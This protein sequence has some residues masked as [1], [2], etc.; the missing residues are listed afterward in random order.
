MSIVQSAYIRHVLEGV[1]ARVA[2]AAEVLDWADGQATLNAD[3]LIPPIRSGDESAKKA[4]ER[5]KK[6]VQNFGPRAI[7]YKRAAAIGTVNWGG[8]NPNNIDARLDNIDLES[9]AKRALKNLVALGIAG[10]IPHAPEGHKPRLQILGGYL[11]P[12]YDKGDNEEPAAW[13][14]VTAETSGN[15]F[16]LRIYEP[17]PLTPL[18]GT[19]TEWREQRH[20]W[21]FGNAPSSVLEGVL[22]PTVVMSDTD[23]AGLPIGELAQALPVLKA[24]IA[25]QI[26]ILRAAEANV[27]PTRWA[28]GDW[29]FGNTKGAEDVLIAQSADSSIGVIDPPGLGTLFEQH[30]RILERVRGD[31]KLPVSS[32]T[33]GTFPS[34]EALDQANAIANATAREYATAIARLLTGGV[35]GFALALGMSDDDA[36]PVSVE[37]NREQERR[38]VSEQI[39]LDWRDGLISFRAAVTAVSQFY[40]TWE[41]KDVEAF[42]KANEELLP[43]PETVNSTAL[44]TFEPVEVE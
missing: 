8:D 14:Q 33:T 3:E 31:L 26:R 36:P 38:S 21:E 10:V 35:R 25:Q 37:V 5:F 18:V 7:A 42:I 44:E 27:H 16:R 34:G 28:A 29:D 43:E 15:T 13:L 24:E 20:A 9:R 39:R 41:S 4:W 19:V 17:D 30:D 22:M 1:S 40:P 12:L 11:E 32:I 23:Q 6:Q 2:A